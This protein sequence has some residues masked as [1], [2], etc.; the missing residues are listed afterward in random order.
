VLEVGFGGGVILPSL[1][2]GAG[3][4]AGLDR[5]TDVVRLANARFRTAV[6]ED[7]AE[8]QTACVESIPYECG[9]FTKICTVHTVYFWRNLMEAFSEIFRVLAP[10]GR[11]AV[12]FLPQPLMD[13]MGLPADVFKLRTSEEV[14]GALV[15][16]GFRQVRTALPENPKPWNVIVAE[17]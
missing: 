16:A 2:A 14:A 15:K 12:G 7:R 10:N 1:I 13:R 8:F 5:S 3:F 6:E 4:V 11:L 17:R 9:Y